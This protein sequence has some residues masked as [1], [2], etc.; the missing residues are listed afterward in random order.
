M[1]RYGA[2]KGI[3]LVTAIL[4]VAL[5][6]IASA[7]ILA[8]ANIA[9][10]RTSNLQDSELAWWYASGVESFI[11]SVLE[12]DAEN[13]RTDS[14]AD[15]WAKAVDYLPVDEGFVRG[16]VIDLQGR[17]NL[18]NLGAGVPGDG[19]FEKQQQIFVRLLG[20]AG[21]ESEQEARAIAAA[22]RDWIDAD[23]EPTGFDGAEDTEYLGRSPL[24]Y[25]VPN[26]PMVSVSELL[27]VKGMSREVYAQLRDWVAA[28]PPPKNQFKIEP[29]N[30]NTAPEAVLRALTS[31]P[32]PELEA[33]MRERVEKPA[34]STSDPRLG[35]GLGGVPLTVASAH[36]LLRAE[37][38]IGS[39]RVGLYSFYFRPPNGGAPVIYGR[40]TDTE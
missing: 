3:A 18:N 15:N 14:F 26:R 35:A 24:P 27:A 40:S 20:A 10:R 30:V 31:Q 36:F 28:L 13:N 11:R 22:T 37:I 21:V 6:A 29:I 1:K 33:F 39:S 23:S 4:V 5:A 8:S 32:T 17:F 9:I 16:Q 19:N 38:Y 7:T 2:Q 34:E 12:R 25:R